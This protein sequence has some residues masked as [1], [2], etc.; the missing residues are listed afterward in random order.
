M[1]RGDLGVCVMPR[2]IAER[3][4]ELAACR[5]ARHAPSWKVVVVRPHGEPPAAVAALLRHITWRRR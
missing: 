2:S 5:F 1:V 3:F 4:P